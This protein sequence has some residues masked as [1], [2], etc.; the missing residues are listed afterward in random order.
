MLTGTIHVVAQMFEKYNAVSLPQHCPAHLFTPQHTCIT[1]CP[2]WQVLRGLQSES[3]F[4]KNNMIKLCCPKDKAKEYQGTA[5]ISELANGTLPFEEAKKSLNIYTTTLHAV[6]SAVIKLGKLTKAQTVYRGIGGKA[7]PKEFWTANDFNVR[8]GVEPAFMSTT[9][10]REVAMTYAS[11]S[12]VGIVLAIRQGMVNRGA[13]LSWLSQYPHE[14][15]CVAMPAHATALYSLPSA[16]TFTHV[17]CLP[18]CGRVLFGPLTGIE[19]LSTKIDGSVV[20]IECDFSINLTA[21]TLEQVQGKRRNLIDQ[22]SEQIVDQQINL[23]LKG[24]GFAEQGV[25]LMKDEVAVARKDPEWYNEDANFLAAVQAVLDAKARVLGAA[26]LDWIA[27]LAVVEAEQHAPFVLESAKSRDEKKVRLALTVF[28][29][30]VS[31]VLESAERAD[32]NKVR[33]ALTA[34]NSFEL[35]SAERADEN[36]VRVALTVLNSFE[37]F[38]TWKALMEDFVDERTGRVTK[39]QLKGCGL[40]GRLPR[41]LAFLS[42]LETLD[43]RYNPDL[44]EPTYARDLGLLMPPYDEKGQMYFTDKGRVQAFLKHVALPE[45]KK[46][47]A[48]LLKKHGADGP[49]L[50]RIYDEGSP[51]FESGHWFDKEK[52]LSKWHGVSVDEEGRV[53]GLELDISLLSESVGELNLLQTL[54]LKNCSGL[55]RL[56][57]R[58]GQLKTLQKLHL[59]GCKGL[60][61]LPDLSGL[62]QLKVEYLPRHLQGWKASGY[63][64]FS[65]ATWLDTQ[66]E[67]GMLTE[68]WCPTSLPELPAGLGG[69]K[70]LQN[71][72]L[73]GCSGLLSLPERLSECTALQK[74]DLYGCS[75]LLSLPEQLGELKTLTTLDLAGC[76]GLLSLPDLS[77]LAELK[78]KNLPSHLQPWAASGYKALSFSKAA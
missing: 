3:D 60:L 70:A 54:K 35:E 43:L 18:C 45:G 55:Q 17:L 2:T 47:E 52:D 20:L 49:A 39:L 76:S 44:D 30:T 68:L 9:L 67:E 33:V 11:G 50:K 37:G 77:G 19:V 7:L 28:N 64:A 15:E 62:A 10:N 21:L 75:G 41:E 26:R 25:A 12:G 51:K 27:R 59:D 40:K 16:C 72:F 56:P 13:D 66:V 24:T 22:M 58:L 42:D 78:V 32:E 65:F 38:T 61:S 31:G 14:Q 8:G 1:P 57:K 46:E 29:S 53:L 34:L 36:K 23:V 6:N 63:K 5:K 74:L 71:L 48:W 73:E 69:L 4:L